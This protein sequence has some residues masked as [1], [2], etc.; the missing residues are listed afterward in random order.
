MQL[1]ANDRTDTSNTLFQH[2]KRPDWGLATRVWRVDDKR[3]YQ[4][5]DG[6]LRIFK[7]RFDALLRPVDRPV[8]ERDRVLAELGKASDRRDA[9][10]RIAGQ[11]A[12]IDPRDQIA[13]FSTLFPKG[14]QGAKWAR[15]H[16]GI[17][18]RKQLKRHRQPVIDAAGD[19]LTPERLRAHVDGDL[20][21]II[22]DRLRTLAGSTDLVT[23]AAA[24]GL[25][26]VDA[27]AG[28]RIVG[29]L[30]D[31]LTDDR[32]VAT[33]FD[34]W[35]TALTRAL[36]RT[37]SWELATSIPALARP[38]RFTAVKRSTF[39]RA[40][41]WLAPNL[42]I[43]A[44]PA[45]HVYRRVQDMISTLTRLLAEAGLRPRDRLDVFDFVQLTLCPK[46]VAQIVASQH[47]D[48]VERAAA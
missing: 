8:D 12:P 34:V 22:I 43:D 40:A 19:L 13:Y 38:D 16:R 26:R 32:E 47:A 42:T 37:P 36:G 39:R 35:V 9:A 48:T 33:A 3:A 14:F 31:L 41:A 30:A 45:G 6:R 1:T 20:S 29:A 25:E 28:A 46:A 17:D 2:I 4:F 10:K 7:A 11:H 23:K 27:V 5:Q 15:A 18:A 44:A 21:L 24:R